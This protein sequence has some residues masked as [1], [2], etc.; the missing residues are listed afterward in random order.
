MCLKFWVA[1]HIVYAG[2][3]DAGP[4]A[5]HRRFYYVPINKVRKYAPLLRF[6]REPI[7]RLLLFSSWPGRQCRPPAARW[8]VQEAFPPVISV[9]I[10]TPASRLL[11]IAKNSHICKSMQCNADRRAGRTEQHILPPIHPIPHCSLPFFWMHLPS[12]YSS[13][14][15]CVCGVVPGGGWRRLA[16]SRPLLT[17]T[18]GQAAA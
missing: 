8:P 2:L 5:R 6:K 14:S 18:E 13:T 3:S 9:R 12:Y 10:K 17:I 4:S 15:V 1:T 16:P 7:S 11:P